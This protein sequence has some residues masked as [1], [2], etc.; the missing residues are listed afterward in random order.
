[1]STH[2][3]LR[4]LREPPSLT[5]R[6]RNVALTLKARR[7][8][9]RDARGHAIDFATPG[10][11]TSHSSEWVKMHDRATNSPKDDRLTKWVTEEKGWGRGEYYRNS[12][13]GP[14]HKLAAPEE[15]F[16]E[17]FRASF[18]SPESR[19]LLDKHFPFLRQKVA[20]SLCDRL[21]IKLRPV[22]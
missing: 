21:G 18:A 12:N 17:T 19:A 4:F 16:A 22:S 9:P 2:R 3:D 5:Q 15:L 11:Q 20:R 1:M 10:A 14:E 13:Y 6:I 7:N 8:Q